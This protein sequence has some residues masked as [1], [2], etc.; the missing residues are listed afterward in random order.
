MLKRPPVFREAE[1]MDVFDRKRLMRRRRA[2]WESPLVG[3]AHG[4]I[5]SAHVAI[6]EDSLDFVR[7]LPEARA[8]PFASGRRTGR[9]L[10]RSPSASWFT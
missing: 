6:D 8:Q 9:A 2:R 5:G 1:E 3:A 4:H 7:Q 10:A